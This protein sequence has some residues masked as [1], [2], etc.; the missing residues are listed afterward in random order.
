MHPA[1]LIGFAI[2]FGLLAA[3]GFYAWSGLPAS[4][5]YLPADYYIALI[6][7]ALCAILVGVALMA[8]VFYSHRRGYDDPPNYRNDR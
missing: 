5:E 3:A 6:M 2:L 4:G 7:G 1:T 8:L